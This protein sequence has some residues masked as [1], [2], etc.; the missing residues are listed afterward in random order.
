MVIAMRGKDEFNI[1]IPYVRF[2][3]QDISETPVVLDTNIIIDGRIMKLCSTKFLEGRLIIPRF[4]LRELQYIADSEDNLRKARGRRGLEILNQLQK[5]PAIDIKIHE[6]DFPEIQD[7]DAKIIRLAKLLN[8]K[9]LTNDYNLAQV[10][11]L[12]RITVLNINELARALKP[13]VM[14]GET[15]SILVIKE[16]KE[17][18]QGIGYLDDGTMIVIEQGKQFIGQ[19]IKIEITSMLQTQAGQMIFSKPASFNKEHNSPRKKA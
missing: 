11:E 16:G 14:P 5:T 2:T 12:Q 3:R 13:V 4:V 7:V 19:T 17:H 10:A 1:V 8:G 6:E 9:I 15:L 18:N